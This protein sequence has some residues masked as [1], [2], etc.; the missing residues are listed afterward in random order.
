MA[1]KCELIPVEVDKVDTMYR[2]ICTAIPVPESIPL[3]ETLRKYEPRSMGM[4]VPVVWGKAEGFQVY[5]PYGNCWIDFTSGI[6][7]ANCGHSHPHVKKALKEHIDNKPL[8]TYLFATETRAKLV[9]KL[10]EITPPNL[11]KVFLLSTGSESV[12]VAIKLAKLYGLSKN[13]QKKGIVSFEGCFHG[14]TTGSQMLSPSEEGKKWITTLDPE[15][16]HIPFPRCGGGEC[17]WGKDEYENC[18]KECFEKCLAQLEKKGVDLKSIA[19]M[20]FEGFQGGRGP[21]FLPNDYAKAMR[22]WADENESLIVVDEIQSGFGRTGKLFTYM[23][24]GI[25]ADI[26]CCGKGISSSLPLSAVL[27]RAD[28]MDMPGP[29]QMT[30]THT[31]NPLCCAATLAAIEVIENENLIEASAQKGKLVQ[32]MFKKIQAKYPD[33]I[34]KITGKG[35][36]HTL[37]FVKPGTNEPDIELENEVV[38]RSIQ[39]GVMLFITNNGTVKI[40]PPLLIT[41]EALIDGI[42]VIGESLDQC[43]AKK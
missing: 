27:A 33:R 36:V 40:C 9:K 23:H 4:Q 24:Y 29:G 31:G 16:Y 30:S 1:Y 34:T 43:L 41:Q 15:I 19:A 22:Q 21:I 6:L 5:D 7:V 25:D 13:P 8:H 38:L 2:K 10:I 12:E 20:I 28:I 39:K 37:F 42:N 35:L 18:G 14:R 17:P 26:V 3:F 32:D 11:T